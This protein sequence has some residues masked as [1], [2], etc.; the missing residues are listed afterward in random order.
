MGQQKDLEKRNLNEILWKS[1]PFV[2]KEM[3]F[4]CRVEMW[5]EKL[6]FSPKKIIINQ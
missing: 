2:G 3:A 6:H 1:G 5:I 4:C